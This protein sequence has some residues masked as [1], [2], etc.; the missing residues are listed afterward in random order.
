ME[1]AIQSWLTDKEIE[2]I[3]SG[4][5]WSNEEEEK[6]KDWYILDGNTEKILRY[7]KKKTTYYAEYESILDFSRKMGIPLKGVGADLAAGVCWTTALL[8]RVDD[9]EKIYAT[10]ISKHRLLKIAPLVI[11]LFNGCGNKITRV[12]GSFYDIKLP[13]QSLDFCFMSQAFHHAD[14][15]VRLLGEIRRVLKPSGV[16]L[17]IGESP[18]NSTDFIKEYIKNTIKVILPVRKLKKRVVYEIFPKF[19]QL[20]SA[21]NESG[22]HFYRINDYV[23]LFNRCG[24]RLYIN[25]E[26]GFTNFLA[27]KETKEG[28]KHGSN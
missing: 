8:S 27:V 5:Y 17:I 13:D 15:P 9:I 3:Y 10:E 21:D 7:L 1:T 2:T 6:N 28:Y 22:D 24:F 11:D 18:V 19:N 25:K 4:R 20:F 14:D 12:I 26:R 23:D 16:V